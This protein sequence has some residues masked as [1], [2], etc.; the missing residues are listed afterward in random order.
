MAFLSRQVKYHFTSILNKLFL[1]VYLLYKLLSFWMIYFLLLPFP[2]LPFYLPLFLHF[3][4]F[5]FTHLSVF[6]PMISSCLFS[7]CLLLS[8]LASFFTFF[9]HRWILPLLCGK[10][11]QSVSLVIQQGATTGIVPDPAGATPL[12]GPMT[13]PWSSR[14]R[15]SITGTNTTSS[16]DDTVTLVASLMI[17][18]PLFNFY[19]SFIRMNTKHNYNVKKKKVTKTYFGCSEVRTT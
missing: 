15:L 17:E 14:G 1:S 10:A 9:S 19:T 18:N 13:T 16:P 3:T 5:F 6:P 2:F 11:F 4:F 12:S 7:I 8:P